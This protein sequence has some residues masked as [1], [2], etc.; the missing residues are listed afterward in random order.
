L[1]ENVL[2]NAEKLAMVGRSRT[3]IRRLCKLRG[4]WQFE[5]GNWPAAVDS[6]HN[7]VRMAREIEK[8]DTESETWLVL[9]KLHLGQLSEPVH[10]AERLE[11]FK[12]PAFRP[13]AELWLAL[14]NQDKARQYALKAYK[15]ASAEGEPYVYRYDLNKAAALL[16][17]L[18][19]EIPQLSPYDP[20]KDEKLPWEDKVVERIEQ[21]KM[22]K[23][24]KEKIE[25]KE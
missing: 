19:V 18:G 13:L 2:A 24:E 16:T 6:L 9:A 15:E 3:S 11:Q 22:E 21:L 14:G 25:Q 5:K 1:Q 12:G 7:A 8:A 4:I 20:A 17:Q 10:E 23:L